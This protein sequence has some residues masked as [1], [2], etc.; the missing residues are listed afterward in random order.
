MFMCTA[1]SRLLTTTISCHVESPVLTRSVSIAQI[2]APSCRLRQCNSLNFPSHNNKVQS[3][4][5]RTAF[6]HRTKEHWF[7]FLQIW[8]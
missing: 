6:D 7:I 4:R 8:N 1:Y 3:P 2:S 5:I